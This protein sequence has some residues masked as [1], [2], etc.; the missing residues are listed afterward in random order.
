MNRQI[1]KELE[2][3]SK[4]IEK[5]TANLDDYK[6][7]ET[8]LLKGGLTHDYI[9]SYLNR[10]GFNSWED[11]VIARNKKQNNKD[12]EATLVG[13]IIGLGLGLLLL[14]IFGDNNK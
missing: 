7:Y 14:G 12:N 8:L 9:F 11:F 13:G 6:S 3:L 2:L 4:K 10:A 1:K 5:N